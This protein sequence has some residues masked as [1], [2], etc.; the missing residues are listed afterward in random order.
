MIRNRRAGKPDE[1]KRFDTRARRPAIDCRPGLL[2]VL[3][4]QVNEDEHMVRKFVFIFLTLLVPALLGVGTA[5]GEASDNARLFIVHFETGPAWNDALPPEEQTQFR[6]HSK[7]LN[8]LRKGKVI[9]F[10]ARYGDLGVIVIR[11]VSLSAARSLIEDDPGVR[12][13]IFDFRIEPLSVFY[14]WEIQ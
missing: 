4:A 3:P 1:S 12:S 7:N 9:V 5:A 2:P 6:E 13:G 10:G 11:A 8:L 14:P